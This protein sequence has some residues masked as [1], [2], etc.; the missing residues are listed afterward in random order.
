MR[1]QFVE[2]TKVNRE[3]LSWGQLAYLS[4]PSF[5]GAKSLVTIEVQIG[6]GGGHSF[7]KHPKQ[8]EV[9]YVISGRIEQWLEKEKKILGPGDSIF[10]PPNTVHAS[11]NVFKEDAKVLAILGPCAGEDGYE[12][13]DVFNE[14]PW[15][16]LR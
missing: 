6:N 5:T 3:K 9:I 4:R 13:V 11:F 1:G 10:I 15:N 7:H 14:A 8:E 16:S 12:V 2:A